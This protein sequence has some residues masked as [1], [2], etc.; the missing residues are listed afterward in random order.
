MNRRSQM[1]GGK[2]R[3]G[4]SGTFIGWKSEAVRHERH[5]SNAWRYKLD[6]AERD[7]CKLVL[8][9]LSP[10]GNLR[11]Y[12]MNRRSQIQGGKYWTLPKEINANRFF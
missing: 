3:T 10:A 6:F 5:I 12:D 8:L 9:G 1:Q 7:K 2:N 4:S 11:R